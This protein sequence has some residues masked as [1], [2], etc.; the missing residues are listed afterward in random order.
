MDV[1]GATAEP[2]HMQSRKEMIMH[3]IHCTAFDPHPSVGFVG[4]EG[5]WVRRGVRGGAVALL[6]VMLAALTVTLAERALAP[7]PLPSVPQTQGA[8]AL[9]G[10]TPAAQAVISRARGAA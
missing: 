7:S 8:E 3:A 5:V 4:D 9:A 2:P 1:S 6:A 10:L